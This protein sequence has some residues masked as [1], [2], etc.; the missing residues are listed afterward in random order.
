MSK[1]VR[2]LSINYCALGADEQCIILFI[3]YFRPIVR[4]LFRFPLL[5]ST[6]MFFLTFYFSI[7]L[8]VCGETYVNGVAVAAIWSG[9]AI[10]QEE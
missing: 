4:I 9:K 6:T 3:I 2:E 8:C 1:S 5:L 10:Y 7:S